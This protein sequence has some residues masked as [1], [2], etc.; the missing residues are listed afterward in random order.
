MISIGEETGNVESILEQLAEHYEQE[1]DDTMKN[2]SSIIEPLLLIVI[3]VVV[4]FLAM[5]L[6][7]PIYNIG[8][9][10]Q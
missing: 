9:S 8:Q 1:I 3:G 10:I 6:I 4:G 7:M 5:A 2:I